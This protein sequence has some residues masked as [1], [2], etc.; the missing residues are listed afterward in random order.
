MK[1]TVLT[2]LLIP[3]FCFSSEA[4]RFIQKT[5]ALWMLIENLQAQ[6]QN[7]TLTDPESKRELKKLTSLPFTVLIKNTYKKAQGAIAQEKYLQEELLA[8]SMAN[9]KISE[10]LCPTPAPE[11]IPERPQGPKLKITIKSAEERFDSFSNRN[12]WNWEQGLKNQS[13][14]KLWANTNN[15]QPV[16]PS[17][18]SFYNAGSLSSI[19]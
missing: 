9:T 12:D 5:H 11:E 15:E 4:E 19:W 1:K 3:N 2:L 18:F 16:Q 14:K 6:V 17:T 7:G 13:V 10:S 8:Q